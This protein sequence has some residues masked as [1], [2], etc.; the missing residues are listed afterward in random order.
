M[1]DFLAYSRSQASAQ[2]FYGLGDELRSRAHVHSI[3]IES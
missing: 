2:A 1:V 3:K